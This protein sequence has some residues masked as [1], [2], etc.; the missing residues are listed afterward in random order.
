MKP[1]NIFTAS[2]I[3]MKTCTQPRLFLRSGSRSSLR[4]WLSKSLMTL[5]TLSTSLIFKPKTLHV[6]HFVVLFVG[7]SVPRLWGCSWTS[8]KNSKCITRACARK[9]LCF[10]LWMILGMSYT[11]CTLKIVFDLYSRMCFDRF[12]I[13]CL[14]GPLSGIMNHLLIME[15]LRTQGGWWWMISEG[16]SSWI[17]HSKENCSFK[18]S[19]QTCIISLCLG[20]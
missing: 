20:T 11:Y 6:I 12:C 13:V 17:R 14:C 19:M 4:L 7:E 5:K 8:S 3:C 9:P 10:W 2:P 18:T 15:T 1:K 16:A